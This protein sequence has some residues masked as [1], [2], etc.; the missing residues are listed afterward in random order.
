MNGLER[1]WCDNKRTRYEEYTPVVQEEQIC[2]VPPV[3]ASRLT[4]T[5]FLQTS[6]KYTRCTKFSLSRAT[7]ISENALI[8]FFNGRTQL[9]TVELWHCPNV[10]DNVLWTL[11]TN[12]PQLRKVSILN[13]PI[14]DEGVQALLEKRGLDIATLELSA[15]DKLTD[16]TLDAIARYCRTIFELSIVACPH[17]TLPVF[18]NVLKSCQDLRHLDLHWGNKQVTDDWLFAIATLGNNITVVNHA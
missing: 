7:F 14:T 11:R 1:D 9:H 10:T 18:K 15:C 4:D 17:F 6:C 5:E 8:A 13:C 16:R 12:C 3:Y 2:L